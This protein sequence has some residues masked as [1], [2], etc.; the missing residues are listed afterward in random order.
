MTCS[1]PDKIRYY[2]LREAAE[3]AIEALTEYGSPQRPY[4]CECDG[5]HLTSKAMQ[6]TT[7][8]LTEAQVIALAQHVL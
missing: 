1:T 6:G 7:G 3:G 5:W 2:S 4:R 8:S